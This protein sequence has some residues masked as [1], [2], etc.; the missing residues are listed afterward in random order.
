VADVVAHVQIKI[1]GRR[2]GALAE[3]SDGPIVFEYAPEFQRSGLEIS[4]LRLPLHLTGP[5][6]FDELRRSPAFEGLPG[7]LAD[8][9]PDS[10]GNKVIR[11]YFAAR[12]EESRALSPVQ[13]L[14]YVGERA[15]G[16]LTYHPAIEIPARAAELQALEI[17]ELVRNARRIVEGAPDV[18]VPEIYR[19]GSSAGGMRPK[20]VVLFNPHT[21]EIRSAF[22]EP[23]AGDVPTIL[24][25]D[26]VG[27]GATSERLGRTMPFNRVEAAYNRM[28]R[29]AGIDVSDVGVLHEGEH[30]HLLVRRFDIAPDGTRIHQHTLGGL[31]HVDYNQ[32]GASSYEE[33]LRT[34]LR[35]GMPYA[36]LQEGYRRAVFNILAVNQDDHVKNLSF[37][38]DTSG[39]WRLAPAYDLTFAK[40]GG[41]TA[42][43]QMRIRDLTAGIREGH[44]LELADELGVTR[45]RRIIDQVASAVA[46]WPKHAA[47]QGVPAE[48]VKRIETELDARHREIIFPS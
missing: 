30:A 22:A 28:A 45:P 4:P 23:H 37:H 13:R 42:R 12:G 43:H 5:L 35:L 46:S 18:A 33:Y 16:A 41:W 25:F 11:A 9:L 48:H 29:D 47:E 27:D 8:S 44:L 3:L 14:L 21:R 6:R 17:A 36:S 1:W 7:V 40:G 10:F 39:T 31:L 2:V 19:I 20:A 24:K 38:M 26:G 15:L 32:P 34:I